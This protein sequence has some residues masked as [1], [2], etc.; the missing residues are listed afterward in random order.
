PSDLRASLLRLLQLT[1]GAM[2]LVSG[3]PIVDLDHLFTPLKLPAIGGHGAE[4]RMR[5]DDV[6]PA[7]T[8][9]SQDLRRHLAEATMLDPGIVIEDKGYSLALHYRLAPRCAER[10]RK[11][12]AACRAA[13]SSEPTELL[14]G[15]AMFEVKR[16]GINKGD[17]VRNLMT[18]APFAGR[19]PVFI[20]DDVTD[21]TVFE[22]LPSLGGKAFSVTHYFP[23]LSGTFRSPAQV[24]N[25]LQRLAAQE[26]AVAANAQ[27]QPS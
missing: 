3:R 8:A 9:L 27:A 2:A 19:M 1:D 6:T 20:G 25:A 15:K 7:A 26:L 21:E 22:V 5:G 23:G 12:V 24:R 16:P 11:H 13:F 17:A 10:L 14:L 4:M 18:L